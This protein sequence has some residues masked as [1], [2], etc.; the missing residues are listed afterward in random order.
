METQTETQ[1][2]PSKIMQIGTGFMASKTL[3]TAVNL[4]LFSLI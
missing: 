1:V 2:T 4:D 3:L